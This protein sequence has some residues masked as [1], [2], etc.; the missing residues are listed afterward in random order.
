MATPE[1]QAEIEI[2]QKLKQ[3]K[4][5][6]ILKKSKIQ[7]YGRRPFISSTIAALLAPFSSIRIIIQLKNFSENLNNLLYYNEIDIT[8]LLIKNQGYF[9]L[10]KIA[11][12][13]FA[14]N[15]LRYFAN[16]ISIQHIL[17][18]IK[19][20]P[21]NESLPKRVL[22]LTFSRI[23]EILMI[24]AQIIDFNGYIRSTKI[25]GNF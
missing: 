20:S 15:F 7:F 23:I 2:F 13:N 22:K 24:P 16:Q 3:R 10:W 5:K 14:Q 21:K 17:P 25:Q 9:S 8:K 6:I 19:F 11:P 12:L 1:Q 18:K 4:M